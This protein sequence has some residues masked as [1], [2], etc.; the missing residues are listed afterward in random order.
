FAGSRDIFGYHMWAQ[1]LIQTDAGLRWVDLDATLDP[2][3]YDATHLALV[4]SAMS[5][6]LA[7]R[8]LLGIAA[9]MGRLSLS[10]VEVEHRR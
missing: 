2:P 9:A 8:E 5:D 1:A 10:V 4:T 7:A 3:G 6:D